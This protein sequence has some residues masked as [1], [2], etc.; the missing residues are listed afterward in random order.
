MRKHELITKLIYCLPQG[1]AVEEWKKKPFILMRFWLVSILSFSNLWLYIVVP[2]CGH[3]LAIYS[4]SIFSE[5]VNSDMITSETPEAIMVI[6]SCLCVLNPKMLFFF[7][8]VTM[9]GSF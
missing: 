3:K 2:L 6:V 9:S 4:S 7:I 1:S 5:Y 8:S